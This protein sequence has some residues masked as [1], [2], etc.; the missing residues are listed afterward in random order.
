MHPPETWLLPYWSAIEGTN[1]LPHNPP[2]MDNLTK[3]GKAP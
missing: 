1:P 2:V 3:M